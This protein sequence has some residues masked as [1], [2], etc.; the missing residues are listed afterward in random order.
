M[1]KIPSPGHCSPG[2]DNR[3]TIY[4]HRNKERTQNKKNKLYFFSC[5]SDLERKHGPLIS[6]FDAKVLGLIS[7]QN[8]LGMYKIILLLT[9]FDLNIFVYAALTILDLI[10]L[11]NFCQNTLIISS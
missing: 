7:S 9:L 6:F 1:W 3:K 5:E 11:I 2:S 8:G 10:I 4:I